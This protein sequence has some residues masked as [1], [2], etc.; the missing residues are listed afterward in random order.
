MFIR[1]FKMLIQIVKQYSHFTGPTSIQKAY[2]NIQNLYPNS[3]KNLYTFKIFIRI[4]QKYFPGT[5]SIQNVH[6][7]GPLF[8]LAAMPGPWAGALDC[9]ISNHHDLDLDCDDSNHY[10]SSSSLL[11]SR[12]AL[13]MGRK[14]SFHLIALWNFWSSWFGLQ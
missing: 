6:P 10:L 14:R 7:P 2:L 3:Q 8:W 1:I 13:T 4:I 9:N 11:T 12:Y 5:M